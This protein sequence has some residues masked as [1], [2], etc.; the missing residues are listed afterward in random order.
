MPANQILYSDKYMDDHYGAVARRACSCGDLC[1]RHACT[2]S[3]QAQPAGADPPRPSA[4]PAAEYRHVI[5]P[6]DIAQLVPK[7]KLMSEV[8]VGGW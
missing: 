4:A 3:R 5:L 2:H 1:P 6:S 8:G 7:G